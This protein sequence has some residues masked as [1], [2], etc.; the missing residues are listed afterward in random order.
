MKDNALQVNSDFCM[1]FE[2]D[3]IFVFETW[4]FPLG[5]GC[6]EGCRGTVVLVDTLSGA[7][8]GNT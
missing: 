2:L 6:C 8:L 5:L 3:E 7:D 1:F 4:P